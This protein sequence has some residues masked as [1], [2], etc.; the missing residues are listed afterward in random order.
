MKLNNIKFFSLF[1]IL[2]FG[3]LVSC[4]E[5]SSTED[6]IGGQNYVSFENNTIVL[7]EA[8]QT[9]VKEVTIYASQAASVDRTLELQVITAPISA[10]TV[11]GVPTNPSTTTANPDYYSVPTSVTIPAGAKEVSFPIEIEG[12][13]IGTGRTIVVE[14]KPQPGLMVASSLSGSL[15]NDNLTANSKR[16]ILN[17]KEVCNLNPIRVQITTDRYGSETTWELYNSLGAVIASGGPW[18]DGTA[19]QAYPRPNVDL[20]LESGTYTFV[21]Y[22]SFGD[23]MNAGTGVG[24]YRLVKMNTDFTVEGEV[25]ATGGTFSDFDSV[26]F[27]LP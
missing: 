19:N 13:D 24:F 17:I 23:G 12:F 18:A 14:I 10:A 9:V 11:I 5:E 27:T 3:A 2:L 21:V 8:G 22:D 7:I 26:E 6:L 25:I 15:T 20:C 4:E 16:L 1:A